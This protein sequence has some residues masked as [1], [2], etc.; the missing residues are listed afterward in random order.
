LSNP[1]IQDVVADVDRTFIGN[2]GESMPP[3]KALPSAGGWLI[4]W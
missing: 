4:G 1:E 3:P 2:A